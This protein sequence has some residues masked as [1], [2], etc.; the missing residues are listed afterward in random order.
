MI[1]QN[2]CVDFIFYGTVFNTLV[3]LQCNH[4]PLFDEAIINA[5]QQVAKNFAKNKEAYD[6]ITDTTRIDFFDESKIIC[7]ESIAHQKH[8]MVWLNSITP[9]LLIDDFSYC[10]VYRNSNHRN[11]D[12]ISFTNY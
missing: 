9:D 8:Y 7:R 5:A 11:L 6:E 12:L 1:D 4:S 10:Y 2:P 3:C